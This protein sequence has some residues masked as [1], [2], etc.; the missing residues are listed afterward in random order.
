MKKEARRTASPHKIVRLDIPIQQSYDDFIRRFETAV[1]MLNQEQ[2]LRCFGSHGTSRPVASTKGGRE[3]E[4]P[5][6]VNQVN[7]RAIPE[8]RRN[9]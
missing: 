9:S 6:F 1:P 5:P 2:V 4:L 7:R 3:L 8:S